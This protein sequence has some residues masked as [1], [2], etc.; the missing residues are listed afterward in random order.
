MI[1]I[2]FVWWA[3]SMQGLPADKAKAKAWLQAAAEG[4]SK[5]AA[6]YLG[7]MHY[8]AEIGDASKTEAHKWLV[9]GAKRNSSE[10]QCVFDKLGGRVAG[11]RSNCVRPS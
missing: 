7:H 3:M 6:L 4:G 5:D 9:E 8:R 10:A 2:I 11:P 1:V